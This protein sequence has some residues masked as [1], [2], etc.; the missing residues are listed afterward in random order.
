MVTKDLDVEHWS[1][2]NEWYQ[3]QI[4]DVP[5]EAAMHY[6]VSRSDPT[7]PDCEYILKY[8]GFRASNDLR[9]WR[10]ATEYA[11]Y[12]NLWNLVD[13]FFPN[14]GE[15][16]KAGELDGTGPELDVVPM[17]PL[18]FVLDLFRALII[19]LKHITD[20]GVIH[21]DLKLDNIFLAKPQEG[22]AFYDWGVHPLIA[23]F[24]HSRPI[25]SSELF[26]QGFV[27][28]RSPEQ[29]WTH[30]RLSQEP[31]N[32]KTN[33]FQLGYVMAYMFTGTVT[34]DILGTG[35][36]PKPIWLRKPASKDAETQHLDNLFCMPRLKTHF[37]ILLT[38]VMDCLRFE[39]KDR[40]TLEDLL[41]IAD[42]LIKDDD[43]KSGVAEEDLPRNGRIKFKQH[44]N[45]PK[46]DQWGE[47]VAGINNARKPVD[48]HGGLINHQGQRVNAQGQR[49]NEAGEL[50]NHE[51]KR[52]NALGQLLNH[53]GTTVDEFGRRINTENHR[54]NRRGFRINETR[55]NG[56]R[57]LVDQNDNTVDVFGR[58]VDEDG[59][60]VN[61]DGEN[62]DK[63]GRRRVGGEGGRLINSRGEVLK[64][65]GTL[66][67]L[68]DDTHPDSDECSVDPDGDD[69][70]DMVES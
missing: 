42:N 52:I 7:S 57:Q 5:M 14:E 70:E 64:P 32:E 29:T 61:T 20:R 49:I 22:S 19:G 31:Q 44:L 46:W 65:D 13:T 37:S 33:V 43:K 9:L 63:E 16:E 18:R 11:E 51:G 36:A 48:S 58:L 50:L 56:K 45:N 62:C 59:E 6:E 27:Q 1:D 3:G 38:P 67:Q 40:P 28:G 21:R 55:I 34:N 25:P 68:V 8:H 53:H 60:L 47:R 15:I 35:A 12:G 26:P 17:L 69:D 39:Q 4:D 24:G 23:D 10:I 2:P 41:A 30:P 66:L 54:I